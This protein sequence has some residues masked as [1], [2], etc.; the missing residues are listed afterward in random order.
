MARRPQADR[1]GPGSDAAARARGLER[2]CANAEPERARE[3]VFE[4]DVHRARRI[5]AHGGR[6]PRGLSDEDWSRGLSVDARVPRRRARSPR[7]CS[8][9]PSA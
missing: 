3:H 4:L 6:E 8:P 9:T 7:S 2:Q 5:D 1:P